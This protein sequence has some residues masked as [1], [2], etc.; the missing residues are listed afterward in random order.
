MQTDEDWLL[1]EKYR[2]EKSCG[3]FTDCKRLANGEPLAYVIGYTPF[4]DCTISLAS[5]PL[6][7]RP[8]TEYWVEKAITAI[9]KAGEAELRE[10]HI[11]DLCAG[12]GAIGVAVAKAIPDSWV[13]FGEIDPAHLPTITQNLTSNNCNA[14]QSKI[15][16]SNLFEHITQT[17]DFI[18]TNPPYI[19]PALDRTQTSVKDFEPHQ[20][21]YGG[22]NGMELIANIIAQA[23][24]HLIPKG[25]LWIE[26]EPEQAS[27]ISLLASEFGFQCTS[28]H[29]QYHVI[30][31]SILMLQ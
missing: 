23:E 4:L 31:Y 10:L 28:Y 3:F 8:E 5:H 12:S 30:R 6:I 2:G 24:R 14:S 1:S 26:H 13:D 20:A 27:T 21:L 17:Y 16:Q 25:Q 9:K 7:P 22:H 18:L 11:L 15:M 29:D 19:D